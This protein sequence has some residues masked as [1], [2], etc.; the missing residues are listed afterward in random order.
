MIAGLR[1]LIISYI[2]KGNINSNK[3][4]DALKMKYN[5]HIGETA[6]YQ[7]GNM[8]SLVILGTVLFMRGIACSYWTL[9]ILMRFSLHIQTVKMGLF[10]INFKGSK[11]EFFKWLYTSIP[12][13]QTVKALMKCRLL[14]RFITACNFCQNSLLGVSSIQRVQ[15]VFKLVPELKA[16]K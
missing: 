6:D 15:F 1:K 5:S 9:C 16:V 14:R 8:W 13:L 2:R 12:V 11:V 3:R 4:H 10:I 7:L